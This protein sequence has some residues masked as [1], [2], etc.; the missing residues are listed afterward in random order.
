MLKSIER[1]HTA[2]PSLR[3]GWSCILLGSHFTPTQNCEM[4]LRRTLKRKCPMA[5]G[6]GKHN[7]LQGCR[8]L[9]TTHAL[10]DANIWAIQ[11]SLNGLDGFE[12]EHMSLGREH[13]RKDGRGLVGGRIN[14]GF[15]QA[16]HI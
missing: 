10:A 2:A 15:D 7:F 1:G 8:P 13:G 14:D 3:K 9:E 6:G 16:M 4:S 5:A 11:A 12:E